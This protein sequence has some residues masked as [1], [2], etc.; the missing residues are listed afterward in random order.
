M[1][2]ATKPVHTLSA[3]K[4]SYSVVM[5]RLK[6]LAYVVFAATVVVSGACASAAQSV[7]AEPIA[8]PPVAK[9]TWG[10]GGHLLSGGL[11]GDPATQMATM[12]ERGL[13]TYRFD[14]PLTKDKPN[15][16]ADLGKLLSLAKSKGITLH[17]ILYVPFTWGDATDGGKYPATE[18]GLEAQGYDRV[19][20]IVTKFASQITDWE[21]Q[22]ELSLL[23]NFKSG[24]GAAASDYATPLAKQWAAVLRGM[25]RAV[26]DVRAKTGRLLRTVVSTVYADF[27]FIPF[28]ET[29]GV[30]VDKLGYHYYYSATANPYKL[31]VPKGS[32]DL[33]EELRKIGKPVIINRFNAG[34]MYAP[35]KSQAYDDAKALL[36]M[37]THLDYLVSQTTA[38]IEGLEFYELYD[39]P[40]KNAAEPNFG[41]MKNAKQPKIQ[42]LLVALYTCGKLSASEKNQLIVSKLFNAGELWQRLATC[43]P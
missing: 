13:T 2:F 24:D 40:A 38:P 15:A 30:Q 9:W 4:H 43:K 28:L 10:V 19:L 29:Q 1:V 11:W 34:E 32:V 23:P 31:A 3:E 22:N 26:H 6:I 21:L 37:K 20:P 33:F 17:P 42:M 8:P 27:G 18:A 41:L 35:L 12:A 25:A 16:V 39:E 14:V 7:G 36:S 5:T